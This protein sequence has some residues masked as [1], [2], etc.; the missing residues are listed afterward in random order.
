MCAIFFVR[1]IE[2][3]KVNIKLHR[4]VTQ[5]A[6]RVDDNRACDFVFHNNLDDRLLLAKKSAL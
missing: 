2:L 6:Q 3:R 4:L 5:N 1:Q